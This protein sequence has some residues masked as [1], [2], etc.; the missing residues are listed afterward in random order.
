MMF[1]SLRNLLRDRTRINRDKFRLGLE[2]RL[3]RWL[4][5][6]AFSDSQ[7]LLS[8]GQGNSYHL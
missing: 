1:T 8:G 6:V 4:L 2:T 7:L 5:V 3:T